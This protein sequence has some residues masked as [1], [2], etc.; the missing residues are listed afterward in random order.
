[1]IWIHRIGPGIGSNAVEIAK[2]FTTGGGKSYTGGDMAYALINTKEQIQQALPLDELSAH[3]RRFGNLYGIGFAQIGDFNRHEPPA[4]QWD[5]AVDV[6]ATLYPW[7]AKHSAQMWSRLP[8]HLR[9]EL[10]I[11]GHGEIP[12]SYGATSKKEQPHGKEACPGKLWNMDEFRFDVRAVLRQRA[13]ESMSADGWRFT[14]GDS[15]LG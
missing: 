7:L 4:D 2:F 13:G 12:G 3:G 1:L 6:C 10:P 15:L 11:V 14:R 9:D 5:R 8:E